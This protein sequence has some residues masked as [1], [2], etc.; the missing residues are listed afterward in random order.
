MSAGNPTGPE[1]Q[2]AGA[3]LT[4]GG[5]IVLTGNTNARI[6]G[7]GNPVFNI[8]DQVI[9]GRGNIGTNTLSVV[10]H[11]NG[12][13]NANE[14]GQQLN[15]DPDPNGFVNDGI[16]QASNGGVLRID[17]FGGGDFDNT[18]WDYSSFSGL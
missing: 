13:I 2:P 12:L 14:L 4:G 18:E 10:N 1:V 17:G 9:E 8:V 7:V 6:D 15:V 11:S 5:T 3:T 16:M